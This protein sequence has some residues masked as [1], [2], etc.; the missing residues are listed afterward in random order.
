M[1]G[2]AINKGSQ[3]V[4]FQYN[5]PLTSTEFDSHL[6]DVIP[7]GVYKGASLAKIADDTVQVSPWVVAIADGLYLVTGRSSATYNVVGVSASLPMIVM[8]WDYNSI[9]S[10]YIDVKA[11]SKA[12]LTPTDI[13]LGEAL[14]AGP[15]MTG[16]DYSLRTTAM[17]L[18]NFCKVR[19][20]EP[21]SMAVD[22]GAG[23]VNYGT[24]R[25]PVNAQLSPYFVA[26]LSDPRIDLLYVDNAGVIQVEAGVEAGSPVAP[27]H[28][29]KIVLAE[30]YLLTTDTEI[31]ED[32]I[33]D[34]RPFLGLSGQSGYGATVQINQVSHGLSVNDYVIVDGSGDYVLAQADSLANAELVGKVIEVSGVDD[35][36]VAQTGF[37]TT[38]SGLTPGT[39][40]YL[41]PTTA[42]THTDTEP[43]TEGE[44]SK[45]CFIAV[46]TTTG[47]L[48][49]QRSSLIS[50]VTLI[51][52][53]T[54]D[55]VAPVAGQIWFRSDL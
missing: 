49:S 53:L 14:Y 36:T 24:T 35:F 30:I 23:W 50:G 52:S 16:F 44:V 19:P 6:L 2:T 32:M 42:G 29:G 15:T 40:Y 55:P 28:S 20:T 48:I 17:S 21:A 51:Q 11:V 25:A 46:S 5:D 43:S 9:A 10:W 4:F 22:I 8:S 38:E 45:P 12:S 7:T 33:T 34:C 3:N 37:I 41:S 13:V 18:A 54:S 47:F 1:G 26:P 27:S 31:N 39:L